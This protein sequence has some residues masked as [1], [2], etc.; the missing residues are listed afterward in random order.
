L[1]TR[2][3]ERKRARPKRV[4]VGLSRRALGAWG[5]SEARGDPTRGRA[6]KDGDHLE[7]RVRARALWAVGVR[8]KRGGTPGLGAPAPQTAL[9]APDT[10][11][12]GLGKSSRANDRG[13]SPLAGGFEMAGNSF[14]QSFRITTAG[15]SHGP[16]NVVIIDGCPPGLE[17][18]AEDLQVD[19]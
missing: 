16:A 4:G 18:S 19:L 3:R 6:G 10:L 12:E 1:R 7:S 5:P 14:G 2:S 9:R 17:L 11:G 13:R 8:A 15:E